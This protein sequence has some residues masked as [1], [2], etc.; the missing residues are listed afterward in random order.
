MPFNVRQVTPL[1]VTR[2]CQ[3]DYDRRAFDIDYA[4]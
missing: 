1:H 2:D 4:R 3:I